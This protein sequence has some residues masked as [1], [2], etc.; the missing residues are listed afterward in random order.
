MDFT[1]RKRLREYLTKH[2]G[3]LEQCIAEI[4]Q[5]NLSFPEEQN[6]LGPVVD[7]AR[8]NML[9][10]AIEG[11]VRQITGDV[12]PRSVTYRVFSKPPSKT[13]EMLKW[14]GI[15]SVSSVVVSALLGERELS[16]YIRDFL[17]CG[18]VGIAMG[19]KNGSFDRSLELGDYN[20]F[21][22]I[23]SI[24]I[25][26]EAQAEETIAHEYAH[27]QQPTVLR[28]DRLNPAVKEGHATMVAYHAVN[29]LASQKNQ[30]DAARCSALN[31]TSH[32]INCS[33]AL[34]ADPALAERAV[35][36]RGFI[37]SDMEM[38]LS[39]DAGNKYHYGTAAFAV[40][41][42]LNGMDVYRRASR[43]DISF[44]DT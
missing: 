9:A 23:A 28:I 6:G 39:L 4:A 16:A 36:K 43:G 17:G 22:S 44:F 42:R 31:I 29:A 18:A 24:K 2:F 8:V 30:W 38:F 10:P 33:Y 21:R 19:L 40:A 12:N 1:G 25:M 5:R 13:A 32:M 11:Q 7:L 35:L 37:E 3:D 34:Q 15:A 20:G 14:A 41:E 27:H 26:P